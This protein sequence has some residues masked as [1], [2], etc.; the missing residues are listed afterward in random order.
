MHKSIESFVSTG[1]KYKDH[2]GLGTY[3]RVAPAEIEDKNTLPLSCLFDSECSPSGPSL[4]KLA[5]PLL[6]CK[7]LGVVYGFRAA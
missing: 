2:V 6:Y 4:R 7:Y 3:A 5:S 1:I